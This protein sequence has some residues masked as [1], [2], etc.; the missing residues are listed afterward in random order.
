MKLLLTQ[1]SS[2]VKINTK[3]SRNIKTV[4]LIRR[5]TGRRNMNVSLHI[6][7]A[8]NSYLNLVSA[9]SNLKCNLK[10][11]T[12]RTIKMTTPS[13]NMGPNLTLA[14]DQMNKF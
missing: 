12:I 5:I 11:L 2:N 7:S 8:Q 3:M 10:Y 1:I 6:K 14:L 9:M 4:H 13:S